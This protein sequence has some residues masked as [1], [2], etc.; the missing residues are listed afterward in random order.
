MSNMLLKFFVVIAELCLKWDLSIER[1]KMDLFPWR[2]T[3]NVKISSIP[4]KTER[5]GEREQSIKNWISKRQGNKLF[6]LKYLYYMGKIVRVIFDLM[7]YVCAKV[8][9]MPVVQLPST[10]QF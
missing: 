9:I 2:E 7:L 8:I 4:Q 5:E 6:G 3:A 1:A 10:I